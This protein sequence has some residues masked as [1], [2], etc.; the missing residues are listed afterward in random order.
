VKSE[1]T[2]M[3]G[4]IKMNNSGSDHLHCCHNR[5]PNKCVNLSSP[6]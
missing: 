6:I 1:V 4:L 5:A 3:G 2:A